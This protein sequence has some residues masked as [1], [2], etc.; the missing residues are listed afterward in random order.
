MGENRDRVLVI[1]GDGHT[2]EPP[3]MWTKRMDRE[4]WGDWI[5]YREVVDEV[6]DNYWCGGELRGGGKE[7]V[8]AICAR[9][10][11]TPR[12]FKDIVAQLELPGG[13]DP[14]AR[15]ADMDRDGLQAAVLYPTHSL[16]FGP[17]DP[18]QALHD[19]SFVLDCQRTYNDWVAEYCRAYPERLFG[20]ACVPLQD[21][22]LAVQEAERAVGELGL[23]GVFVRP[24]PYIGELALSHHAYDRFWA[25]CQD[26]GVPVAFH[27]GVHVDTPGA[28]RALRLVRESPNLL[29]TNA[30]VD[31]EFGGSAM[32]QAIGNTVDM[33]VTMGRMLLGG[34]CERFPNLKLIFLESGGGWVGTQLERMDEQVEAFPLERIKLLPSEYFK[35]QCWISFDPGEWNLAATATYIGADRILWASDYPHPEYR[36]QVV[37]ELLDNVAGLSE[38]DQRKII[39]ENAIAAYGL[40]MSR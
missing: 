31:E 7:H 27:P 1:D 11:I 35:R 2:V 24:S 23:R 5:P 32:G 39:G 20:V 36:P 25:A 9:H 6:Y 33:I 16:F 28:C 38:D 15:V 4:R 17:L 26:L 3:D 34:V 13:A 22:D 18:I 8:D 37:K 10:G 12:Q 40:S 21:I 29:V 14:H 19:V 30:D